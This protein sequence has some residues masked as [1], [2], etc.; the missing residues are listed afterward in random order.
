MKK[1]LRIV[2]SVILALFMMPALV[3]ASYLTINGEGKISVSK[4]SSGYLVKGTYEISNFGDET[5]KNVFPSLTLG[6]WGWA[7]EPRSLGIK[8]KFLWEISAT[9]SENELQCAATG[10]DLCAGE[11]LPLRGV[12]PLLIRRHYEDTNGAQFSAAEVIGVTIGDLS[13]NEIQRVRARQIDGLL[14]C[15]GDGSEFACSVDGRN[16]SDTPHAVA[17]G[18]HTSQEIQ[19]QTKPSVVTIDGQ[20]AAV[21]HFDIKNFT[22]LMGSKYAVFGVMQWNEGGVR[23]LRTL[24]TTVHLKP[25]DRTNLFIG[26]GA[27]IALLAAFLLYL[28]VFRTSS[29]K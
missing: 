8:E 22:G 29:Q 10:G 3:W 12:F 1:E 7:G 6:A 27:G 5:A 13:T 9:L 2:Y 17:V 20:G 28:F 23:G 16:F 4:E 21:A 11:S 14:L 25:R 24:F 26:L 19:V 15:D 18:L